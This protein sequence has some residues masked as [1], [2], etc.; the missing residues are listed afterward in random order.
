[1]NK[2]PKDIQMAAF[3]LLKEMPFEW[4]QKGFIRIVCTAIAAERRRS[5][6]EDISTAPKDEDIL[7]EINHH[8]GWEYVSQGRWID[9]EEDQIDQPGHDAGFVD[10][11][12]QCFFPGRSFGA[13]KSR[14]D[15]LQPTH[16]MKLPA[17]PTGGEQ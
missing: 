4:T 10:C 6:W 5:Q 13:E 9:R 12:F 1:M 17:A 11:E 14:Y 7:L 15:G 2:F 16:W 8:E 3:D